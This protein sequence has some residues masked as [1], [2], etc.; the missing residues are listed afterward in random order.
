MLLIELLNP[1]TLSQKLYLVGYLLFVLFI[2]FNTI[3]PWKGRDFPNKA[4]ILYSEGTINYDYQQDGRSK[5]LLLVL[6]NVNN[7]S[8]HDKK[9]KIIQKKIK[10]LVAA[11]LLILLPVHQCVLVKNI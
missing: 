3:L 1:K 10:Y 4:D 11:I 7:T 6:D 9:T 2:L 8:A 5:R